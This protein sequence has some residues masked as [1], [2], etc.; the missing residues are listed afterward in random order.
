[1]P[2]DLDAIRARY[3]AA[4]QPPPYIPQRVSVALADIPDLL[5]EVEAGRALWTALRNW[6]EGDP[7]PTEAM[8]AYESARGLHDGS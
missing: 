7:F 5:A 1:M 2:S 3:E 8:V 4:T 6:K